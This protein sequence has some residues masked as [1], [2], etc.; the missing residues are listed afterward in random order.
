[1]FNFK[2]LLIPRVLRF[3]FISL[4]RIVGIVAIC[5]V[6][7]A[8]IHEVVRSVDL[9]FSFHLTL[10][11]DVLHACSNIQG[12]STAL[13]APRDDDAALQGNSSSANATSLASRSAGLSAAGA[14]MSQGIPATTSNGTVSEQTFYAFA[15]ESAN[16][17][18]S[19]VNSSQ[20]A[21]PSDHCGYVHGTTVPD[22]DGGI[23]F[24]TLFRILNGEH[25]CHVL[26]LYC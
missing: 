24:S 19:P 16:A 14:A 1:M 20:T 9:C 26:P 15:A 22:H 23:F 25:E 5:M 6:I 21:T 3:F 17:T 10:T 8:E 18:A 7:G 12:Y 4:I 13:K 11:A 2:A